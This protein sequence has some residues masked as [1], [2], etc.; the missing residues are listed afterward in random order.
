MNETKQRT[1]SVPKLKVF[2]SCVV[3]S[4]ATAC[5]ILVYRARIEGLLTRSSDT[6]PFF[7]SKLKLDS[8][9]SNCSGGPGDKRLQ[10]KTQ[11]WH[12]RAHGETYGKLQLHIQCLYILH[13]LSSSR[14]FSTKY[15]LFTVC[16][17]GISMTC[18]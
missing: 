5:T 17:Q 16:C 3:Y 8:Q 18:I 4:L 6:S 14:W 11:V 7:S 15:R 1:V 2:H 12:R 9:L 10:M 13:L